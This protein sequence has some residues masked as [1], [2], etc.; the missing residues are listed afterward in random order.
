VSWRS[1]VVPTGVSEWAALR[2]KDLTQFD[3]SGG[4]W[5][6]AQAQSSGYDANEI[7]LKV[8][9]STEAVLRGDAAFERDG[10]AFASSEY[11][12]PVLTG[13]L[14]VAA[15]EGELKVLD[16]GGS[17][18]SLYWQ[19]CKFFTGMKVSWG[20]V[21][22]PSFVTAGKELDQNSVNF[23]PSITDYLKSETPNVII[24]SSV[25]QY[26]PKPEQILQELLSTPANTVILDRTPMSATVSN[27]PCLQVVPQHIYAGSY[28]AWVFS[29]DWLCTQ[30]KGWEILAEFAGIEPEGR[31]KKGIHFAWDGL[32]AR[33][34]NSG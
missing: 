31:T 15:R 29:K 1:W 5:G 8:Q 13:L 7:L 16:F 28:P 19:H 25:L 17:L 23:F 33:R 2:S 20:V 34:K 9:A 18:G 3:D 10:V 6:A 27:I 24:L 26:L 11:R 32:I 22:Q 4:S 21:E 30:L 14:E 12:W